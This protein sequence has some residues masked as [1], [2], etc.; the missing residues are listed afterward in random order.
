MKKCLA[1]LCLL[2]VLLCTACA[3]EP[4]P[5]PTPEPEPVIVTPAPE[6]EP[7]PEPE[8]EPEP[9]VV[10][11]TVTAAGDCTLG[12]NQKQSYPR[13]FHDLY[14]Q[15]GGE[16]FLRSVAPYF[17]SDDFT[18]VNLE[19][20]LTNSD[21]RQLTYYN[22]KFGKELEKLW[23]HKGKPEYVDV[24]TSGSVEAVSMGNNHNR[25]YGEEGYNETVD[26]VAGAGIVYACD[27]TLGRYTT[28]SGVRIG[29]VSVN[30]HYDGSERVSAWLADGI[31]ALREDCDLVLAC[32]HWGNDYDYKIY[33]T[34][35]K[36]GR[37]C[38][39]YGADL[40]IGNHPHVAQ[41][42]ERYNG[43]YIFY[44][45]GNFCYGG[46]KNPADKD[47][48]M[49]QQTFTFVDGALVRDD[50][51]TLIP[52]SI[53]SRSD[54]NDYQPT[55]AEG[56]ERTRILEKVND[57]SEQFGLRFDGDGHPVVEEN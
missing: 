30:E 8:P 52:C 24:L 50:A 51:V 1:A 33:E 35:K 56:D 27:G 44:S 40:V 43:R 11:V 38:I 10:S 53:S 21:D 25:D 7:V 22:Y 55:P 23:N 17:A 29:F 13:S 41:G 39:D 34:Q 37:Q 5:V 4:E 12:T 18:I 54:R 57:A 20:S 6:P 19:C 2:A 28:A 49:M 9:V 15:N 26:V 36:L 42:V 14:D 47:C 46:N 3:P 32:V 45:M 48:L 16:Y 31:A